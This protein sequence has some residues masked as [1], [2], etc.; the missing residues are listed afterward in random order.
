[1]TEIH[2]KRNSVEGAENLLPNLARKLIALYNIYFTNITNSLDEIAAMADEV[3]YEL[4]AVKT[5]EDIWKNDSNVKNVTSDDVLPASESKSS[6]PSTNESPESPVES[7]KPND[8]ATS[9]IKPV[10]FQQQ[11]GN[12]NI[13]PLVGGRLSKYNFYDIAPNTPQYSAD[14]IMLTRTHIAENAKI[15]QRVYIGY[16]GYVGNNATVGD[17]A[18]L[19]DNTKIYL[20]SEV[21][22]KSIVITQT[23]TT[24]LFGMLRAFD[25]VTTM[26]NK[27]LHFE[28]D[29]LLDI[30]SDAEF[31][32]TIANRLSNVFADLK[33]NNTSFEK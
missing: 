3:L 19:C 31:N 4:K 32:A 20:G 28:I 1:M 5:I 24:V 10:L 18:I 33:T 7:D 8:L 12:V 21:A 25:E 2:F 17:D 22:E 30:Q 27:T 16:S 6:S 9:S 14:A 23:D 13:F 26:K 29:G 15:G 11:P